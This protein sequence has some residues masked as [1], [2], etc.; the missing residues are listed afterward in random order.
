M[1]ILLNNTNSEA[2]NS[3]LDLILPWSIQDDF[4]STEVHQVIEAVCYGVVTTSLCLFGIPANMINCLVFW[5]QGLGDRMNLC[6]FSLSLV[7]CLYLGISFSILSVSSLTY[8][9]NQSFSREYY[10]MA[11]CYLGNVFYSLRATSG[12]IGVVIAV[13]RCVCVVFPLRASTLMR[14]RTMGLTLFVCFLVVQG[15]HLIYRFMYLPLAVNTSAGVMWIFLGTQVYLEN[16]LIFETI[17]FTVLGTCLPV[18]SFLVVSSATTVTVIRLRAAMSWRKTTSSTSSDS[19]SQQTALTAM[20]VMV[21]C[22]FVITMAPFV[23]RQVGYFFVGTCSLA[24]RCL[25]FYAAVTAVLH[26]NNVINIFIYY[27]RSS[28]FRLEFLKLFGFTGGP[29]EITIVTSNNYFKTEVDT[30][31]TEQRL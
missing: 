5:R 2:S 22:V 8:L 13:E 27:C 6:L 31:V 23:A 4:I 15:L 3:S 26:I 14:S 16:K 30:D 28:R 20:L 7:D 12:C 21:S 18:I 1:N 29:P 9:Y 24:G 11:I 17:A 10:A 25:Q 19:H